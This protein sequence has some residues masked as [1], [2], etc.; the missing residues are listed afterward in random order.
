MPP[1]LAARLFQKH[2]SLT[3]SPENNSQ[4]APALEAG[5]SMGGWGWILGHNAH[6]P[7]EALRP[8]KGETQGG[9]NENQY[10]DLALAMQSAPVVSSVP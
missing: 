6:F 10:L 2:S 8:W 4:G 7:R 3:L 9:L 5:A 1:H